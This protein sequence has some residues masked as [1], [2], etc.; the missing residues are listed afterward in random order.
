MLEIVCKDLSEGADIGCHGTARSPSVSTNAPSAFDFAPEVTDAV[1]DW[2][3]Q[4]FAA[5]PFSPT[6]R[7]ANAKVSGIMCRQKPNGSARII[8]NFSSP[9]GN[10]VN[11]GIDSKMFPTSM[12]ST[13]RWLGALERAGRGA[14]IMKVDW[15]AAYKH[16]HVRKDDLKLQYFSWLGMDFVELML[17]FGARSSAGIYDRL[18]KLILVLVLAYSR[19]PPELVCQYLD[20][21]CAATPAGSTALKRFESA[22]RAV[23]AEVGVQ[24]APTDDPDKA[25]SPCTAGVVL[26]V[27]YDTVA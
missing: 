5:G 11:D 27:H 2:V 3:A 13:N 7:P 14:L 6:D 8:L 26:G 20:D 24:L 23:A 16:I 9:A 22:Y 17:V 18:A 12:S 4:G 10:C 25:F 21:V 19:F 1:A 15:A